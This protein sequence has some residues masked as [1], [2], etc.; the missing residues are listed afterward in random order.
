MLP[1]APPAEFRHAEQ[2]VRF[3]I[4]GLVAAAVHFALL[5][6]NL[7]VVGLRSAGLANLLA[8]VGGVT[9]SF[10]GSRYFVF[11]APEQALMTQAARFGALYAAIALLHGAILLLWT[12]VGHHDYRVGFLLATGL[13]A[14]LSYTGNRFLVFR[15]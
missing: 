4:N 5:Y 3:G 13:Q 11:R 1:T 14:V 2:V 7:H 8:A 10:F 6:F 9:T 12:D 15:K